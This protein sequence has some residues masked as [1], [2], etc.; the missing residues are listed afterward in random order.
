[1][2]VGQRRFAA[3]INAL[4]ETQRLYATLAFYEELDGQEIAAQLGLT[5]GELAELSRPTMAA[6]GNAAPLTSN[7]INRLS[8]ST[9]ALLA[10]RLERET[11]IT[12]NQKRHAASPRDVVVAT[13]TDDQLDAALVDVQSGSGGELR[14]PTSGGEPDF[15]SA[16]SSC[17]LAV[18]V[19]GPWR[20]DPSRLKLAGQNG[21]ERLQFEVKFPI[22]GVPPTR[23]PPNLDVVAWSRQ[24]V[25]AVESKL[26]ETITSKHTA[27]FDPV[28]DHAIETLADETW[29]RKIELV[30][31]SPDDYRFF[32]AGQII[33]HYLGLKADTNDQLD[34]RPVMLL[35]L[36][37]EP[38]N[39]EIHRFFAQ[40]RAE[41]ADFADS[42]D[43]GDVTF[44]SLS[45]PALW[46]T[47]KEVGDSALSAH[48]AAP[49]AR[50]LLELG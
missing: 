27:H 23:T 39:P 1:M 33:K 34:G 38:A 11:G 18:S 6:L 32:A 24:R 35:Y 42:L 36:Y 31:S 9:Q 49:E 50:Y 43:D 13:V 26:L 28:Y 46:R 15:H 5:S 2:S 30:Q 7:A 21:F 22:I 25:V 40:H 12:L 41:V 29:G 47:W 17:A 19:F 14:R 45:Y 4:P 48:V 37:W 8:T 10:E 16:R 44:H 20:L 3:A